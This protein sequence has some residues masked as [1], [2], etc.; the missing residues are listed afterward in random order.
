MKGGEVP[1]PHAKVREAYEKYVKPIEDYQF[2]VVELA[3]STSLEAVCSI[4]ETL[5]RT[6]IRLSVF[7]LLAARFYAKEWTCVA[8]GSKPSSATRSSKSSRSTGSSYPS[9]TSRSTGIRSP[10]AIAQRWKCCATSAG[11]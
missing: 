8:S 1:I 3:P 6:G 9:R 2:P 5:N 4:F 10:T 11:S 7:D